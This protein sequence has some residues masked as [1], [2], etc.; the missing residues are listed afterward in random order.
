MSEVQVKGCQIE[1]ALRARCAW[2]ADGTDSGG[3]F[4]SHPKARLNNEFERT[5]LELREQISIRALANYLR[6]RWH[7]V[8]EIEKRYLRHKFATI[9][10]SKAQAVGVDEIHIGHGQTNRAP[11]RSYGIWRVAQSFMSAR[12]KAFPHWKE[13]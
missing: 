1:S 6:L 10:T 12:E 3:S 7:T 9:D 13:H 4:H 5:I 11:S 8:K 2:F